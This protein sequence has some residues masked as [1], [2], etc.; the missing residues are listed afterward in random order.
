M[1]KN[2]IILRPV[3]NHPR[4]GWEEAFKAMAQNGDDALPD[5]GEG[6]TNAWDEEEW[7]WT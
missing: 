2:R 5:G 3:S 4:E 6:V 1:E 7:Q